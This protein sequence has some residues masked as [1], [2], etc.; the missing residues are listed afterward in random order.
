MT[1]V[2]GGF[3]DRR[4]F[5]RVSIYT[6]TRYFCPFR[7]MEVGVQARISDLSESGALLMTFSEGAPL[8]AEIAM[9][10]ILPGDKDR[11]TSVKGIVRYTEPFDKELFRSGVEFSEISKRDLRALRAHVASCRKK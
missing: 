8:G 3:T 9:S 4:R 5:V 11:F 7:D 1:E 2:Q 6:I 10:F